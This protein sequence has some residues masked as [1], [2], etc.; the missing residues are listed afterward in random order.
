[1][2]KRFALGLSV[3]V[4]L[5]LAGGLPVLA[6]GV[7]EIFVDTTWTGSEDGT[8]EHP[9]NTIAEGVAVAQAN[10]SGGGYIYT[11]QADGTWSYYKYV[12][13]VR[14]GSLGTPLP[15]L[16]LYVLLIAIFAG[17]AYI[18]NLWLLCLL[19]VADH[20][21]F[22]FNL[23]LETY[24]KK[25]ALPADIT[26]NVSA[27][28]TIN[29]TSAIFIPI[30]GGLIWDLV[31]FETTFLFGAAVALVSFFFCLKLERHP[32]T[33]SGEILAGAGSR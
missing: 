1:M 7:V 25:T 29:H 17:Y 15:Q 12:P 22:G 19:F 26:S 11:R 31:G 21:L 6:Q 5:L 32:G 14:S 18:N 4:L 3:M 28:V 10:P 30:V 16:T 23:A 8:Q 27:G 33:E 24:F 20:V 2:A 13:P 9:Y